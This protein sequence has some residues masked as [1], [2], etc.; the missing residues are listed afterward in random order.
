MT[1]FVE[2]YRER[3]KR[4]TIIGGAPSSWA[5]TTEYNMSKD[6][7]RDIVGCSSLLWANK[8][9]EVKSYRRSPRR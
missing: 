5:A 2:N 1:P 8:P 7:I 3:T 6:L 4:T 9:L